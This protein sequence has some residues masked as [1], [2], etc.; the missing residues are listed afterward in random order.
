M[1][2]AST[3][4]RNLQSSSTDPNKTASPK[5]AQMP[6]NYDEKHELVCYYIVHF[7]GPVVF[8]IILFSYFLWILITTVQDSTNQTILP[9]HT[10]LG[11]SIAL[12]IFAPVLLI[13]HWVFLHFYWR[14]NRHGGGVLPPRD[15]ELEHL[16]GILRPPLEA[17]KAALPS[18]EPGPCDH[19]TRRNP[20]R[21]RIDSLDT[22]RP[23]VDYRSPCSPSLQ[24]VDPTTPRG[25]FAVLEGGMPEPQS[26]SHSLASST[27]M[28]SPLPL[29]APMSFWKDRP[30]N[31]ETESKHTQHSRYGE[32]SPRV[33]FDASVTNHGRSAGV[34]GDDAR[35]WRA[36]ADAR[37]LTDQ[38]SRARKSLSYLR[39]ADAVAANGGGSA[40]ASK[41]GP[42]SRD[43]DFTPYNLSRGSHFE[44]ERGVWV[45]DGPLEDDN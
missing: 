40:A 35:R 32:V 27:I 33:H 7:L 3:L 38:P 20:D 34:G 4:S 29:D 44:S 16:A 10:I 19:E 43:A 2:T 8:V 9:R 41:E 39:T 45:V 37:S 24:D 28:Q 12:L 1:L 21:L 36:P 22:A 6:N 15:F 31:H 30:S 14:R 25:A 42:G 18:Q 11:F 23:S 26:D 17:I 13:A 5:R